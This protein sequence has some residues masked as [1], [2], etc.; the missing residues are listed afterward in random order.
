MVDTPSGRTGVAFHA[1]QHPVPHEPRTHIRFFNAYGA[2]LQGA[3]LA[4]T[5]MC[6]TT[7]S[8]STRSAGRLK[9]SSES[10]GDWHN[11][12]IHSFVFEPREC[13]LLLPIIRRSPAV[14]Y[15]FPESLQHCSVTLMDAHALNNAPQTHRAAHHPP[16]CIPQD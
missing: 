5:E 2:L 8:R 11:M 1:Q 13:L 9:T 15:R 14:R 10:H 3:G 4:C 6:C 7:Y 16:T 12:V